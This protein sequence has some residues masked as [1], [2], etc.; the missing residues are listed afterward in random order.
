MKR[1]T[2][3]LFHWVLPCVVLAAS[4]WGVKLLGQKPKRERR[5]PPPR[6]S[7]P[8]E[9]V[10]AKQHTGTLD[11]R[12]TGV[13]VPFRE[14]ELSAEVAGRVVHKSDSLRPGR[15]VKQG[16]ELLRIDATDYNLE[17]ARLNSE[18]A[19]VDADLSR[20]EI[21][22]ENTR[23]LIDVAAKSVRLR[24]RE[25]AR[26]EKLRRSNAASLTA[27]DAAG[28]VLLDA[29]QTL[30]TQQNL[31]RQL[32]ATNKSLGL[33]KKLASIKL[34]TSQLDLKRTVI[35][36]PV[37]GVVVKTMVETNTFLQP[38]KL[39]AMIDDTSRVE[40]RCSLMAED[41]D[42]VSNVTDRTSQQGLLP[43]STNTGRSEGQPYELPAIPATITYRRGT[44]TYQWRGR[45]SRQDGLGFDERTR[46][47]PVRIEVSEPISGS[48]SLDRN[49][50]QPMALVRG[51]FVDVAL[52]CE[53]QSL[54]AKI[55]ETAL[56]P[57]K[58]VWV[59]RGKE[60]Q[61]EAIRLVRLEGGQ[62]L[63]DLSGSGLSMDDQII[64]SPV[65]NAKEGLA[66]TLAG[67]AKKGRGGKGRNGKRG[68]AKGAKT[69]AT[70]ASPT[71]GT[72]RRSN[73]KTRPGA[74]RS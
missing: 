41:L 35:K 23:R 64:R 47:L 27:I 58:N 62:A 71:E 72:A 33:T 32:E 29:Q 7:I 22:R 54:L 39:I 44:K 48:E 61:F 1:A 45:L 6:V 42:Y 66:I 10:K 57:G 70:K 30:V 67:H 43:T 51:M 69:A 40:V 56:R 12:T 68:P 52:H 9:V 2:Q 5:K 13:A 49:A 28:K 26:L 19:K 3:I 25:V 20:N 34:Q 59:M 46:T 8:V 31:L 15:F 53:S 55:P 21:D 37:S 14:I 60:L 11:V 4:V 50:G 63:I 73:A 65:P 38:G 18:L 36:S 24:E 74:P 17:I 16:E